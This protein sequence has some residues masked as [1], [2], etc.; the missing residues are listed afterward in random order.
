MPIRSVHLY[1]FVDTS[2]TDG[3]VM[4][5]ADRVPCMISKILSPKNLGNEN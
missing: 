3:I 2:S 1:T 4:S 5:P